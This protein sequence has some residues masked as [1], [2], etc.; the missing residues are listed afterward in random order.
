MSYE[1]EMLEKLAMPGKKEVAN[2]LLTVLFRHNGSVKEFASGE[3]IVNEVANIFSL[4]DEQRSAVLERIYRKENRIV[5]TPLWHRLLFRA[6]DLLADSQLVTRPTET[7]LLT[8]QKEWMLTEKGY[9]RAL[10]LVTIPDDERESLPVKSIE[11]QKEI[12]KIQNTVCPADYQ[13]IGALAHKKTITREMRFR[14]RLFRQTVIEGYDYQCCMCG[15]KIKSPDNFAWEVEAAHIVPHS[16]NGKDDVWNGMALC[17]LHHWAFDVGWF[18]FTDDYNILV[19]PKY[20]ELPVDYG[21]M[22]HLN[23]FNDKNRK[24]LLPKN[25]CFYPNRLALQ[26]HREH[27][28]FK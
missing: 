4:N 26:W 25:D 8:N 28:F 1:G 17:R 13:P 19:S 6:A 12:N 21:K 10:K 27:I 14:S 9:E 5:K 24:I 20:E 11:I 18:S 15:L 3:E 23:I 16:L 22:F 7:V 2:A